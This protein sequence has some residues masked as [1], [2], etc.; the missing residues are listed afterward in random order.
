MASPCD[1]R[2][3]ETRYPKLMCAYHH[4]LWSRTYA[5]HRLGCLITDMNKAAQ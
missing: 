4:F 3:W 1:F 2:C 5:S